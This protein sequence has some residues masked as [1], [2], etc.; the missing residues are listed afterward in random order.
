MQRT[1][2]RGTLGAG[3][4]DEN[5]GFVMEEFTTEA[6]DIITREQRST[7]VPK[8]VGRI[9]R[10]CTLYQST[11]TRKRS[12]RPENARDI[13]AINPIDDLNILALQADRVME[14][15][16]PQV[17]STQLEITSLDKKAKATSIEEKLE[18]L[19]K[20]VQ[21]LSLARNTR[22]SL[23]RDRCRSRRRTRSWNRDE[24]SKTNARTQ[25]CYYHSRFGNSARRCILPCG[26]KKPEKSWK[27]SMAEAA[28][29]D[30]H[31]PIQTITSLSVW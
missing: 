3:T 25:V 31:R 12:F 21:L 8:R 6:L 15:I 27:T 17:A 19:E 16:K 13:L 4:T 28:W 26:W 24:T 29:G 1:P 23:S 14:V 11:S 7:S 10:R 18:R 9:T 5:P 30:R 22:R 20:Q 2:P